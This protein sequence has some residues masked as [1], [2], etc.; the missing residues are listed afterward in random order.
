LGQKVSELAN[1]FYE[2]G[3]YSE[4]WDGTDSNGK[5]VSTGVYFYQISA[6]DYN[7]TKKMLLL[8]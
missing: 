2:A 7:E 6:G 3:T 5:N 4:F 8:K 1:G